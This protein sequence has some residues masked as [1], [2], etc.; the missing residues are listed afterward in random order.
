M[1]TDDRKE[2]R[3]STDFAKLYGVLQDLVGKTCLR[4]E[5]SY[6]DELVIHFGD[7]VAYKHPTLSGK[8]RG[9]WVLEA[10]ATPWDFLISRT[11][12][13]VWMRFLQAR[14]Q[15]SRQDARIELLGSLAGTTV[16]NV[17]L[18]IAGIDL[19]VGFSNGIGVLLLSHQA[20]EDPDMPVWE[21]LTPFKMFLQVW[22]KPA[23]SWSYLLS[24]K[25][26]SV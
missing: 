25:P 2:S 19:L 20:E 4:A 16:G 21:L 22:G 3:N 18:G 11:L 7:P 26:V 6:G 10:V 12:S 14:D 5:L 15:K 17:Q 23:P 8:S 1:T 13:D 24:D 9:S